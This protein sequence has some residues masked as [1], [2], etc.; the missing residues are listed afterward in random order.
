MTRKQIIA[1][2]RNLAHNQYL[3]GENDMQADGFH[4][5]DYELG[6]MDKRKL[7]KL[8]KSCNVAATDKGLFFEC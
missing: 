1:E 4:V 8:I 3:W 6:L 7:R 5:D 2:L